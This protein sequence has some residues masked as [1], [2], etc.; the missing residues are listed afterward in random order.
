VF[1][2]KDS[3]I[4]AFHLFVL[5][6]SPFTWTYMLNT[7]GKHFY[8]ASCEKM[9]GT[10]FR[11]NSVLSTAWDIEIKQVPSQW[12]LDKSKVLLSFCAGRGL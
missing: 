2:L 4:Q 3:I 5:A 11:A 8:Y 9:N 7:V 6:F 10:S 1:A 12:A